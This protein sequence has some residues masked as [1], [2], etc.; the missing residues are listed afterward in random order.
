MR[1]HRAVVPQAVPVPPEVITALVVIETTLEGVLSLTA[2][3]GALYTRMPGSAANVNRLT[4][5]LLAELRRM[6]L[7]PVFGPP[8]E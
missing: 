3:G 1:K 6:R 2:R 5:R 7:D 8:A 4:P